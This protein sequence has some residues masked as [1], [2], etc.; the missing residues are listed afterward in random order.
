MNYFTA[1]AN[2]KLVGRIT[3]H[4]HHSSNELYNQRRCYFGYFDCIDD[5]EVASALL[6]SAEKWGR[7]KGCNLLIGNFNLT[8]MQM[9]GVVTSGFDKT[10]YTDQSYNP[11]HI[12]KLL[13]KLRFNK[14]FP[15]RSFEANV[16]AIDAEAIVSDKHKALLTDPNLDWQSYSKKKMKRQL[17]D[18]CYL[19]NDGFKNNPM[20]VALTEEE[21][22]FQAKDL[23]LIIDERISSIRS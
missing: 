21:F 9:I 23:M 12:P 3:A 7:D 6:D 1:Y 8:A 14:I 4:I 16:N 18:T 19:L 17:R 11:P 10:P 13:E 15:T 22:L 5:I 20:F 2:N